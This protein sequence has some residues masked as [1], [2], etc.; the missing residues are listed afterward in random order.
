MSYDVPDDCYYTED[1]EWARIDGS[2]ATVG[3]ADYAQ[4][5]LGD[6]VFFEFP[7]V[8]DEVTQGE[9]FLVVESIKAVSDVYAP[10]SGT[11]V[12]VNEELIDAPELANEAPYGDGWL[13]KIELDDPDEVDAL[14]EPAAYRSEVLESE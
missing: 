8:G 12:A 1:H 4:D 10:V 2:T 11:V 7:A 14:Y 5:E 13:V 9:A 3:I 6:L